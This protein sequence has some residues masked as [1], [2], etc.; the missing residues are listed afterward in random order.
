[1]VAPFK[2]SSVSAPCLWEGRGWWRAVRGTPTVTFCLHFQ[3]NLTDGARQLGGR[4]LTNVPTE[5]FCVISQVLKSWPTALV[6][7]LNYTSW[8]CA[9]RN[10]LQTWSVLNVM[11][12]KIVSSPLILPP[13]LKLAAWPKAPTHFLQLEP[14]CPRWEGCDHSLLCIVTAQSASTPEGGWVVATHLEYVYK[15]WLHALHDH[16]LIYEYGSHYDWFPS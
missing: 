15:T 14:F 3:S 1:M 9:G 6:F 4:H 2:Q 10:K 16:A 13:W 5:A 7:S 8:C 11:P 12:Q